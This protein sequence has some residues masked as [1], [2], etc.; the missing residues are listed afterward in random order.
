MV[1][2]TI[3]L[4]RHNCKSDRCPIELTFPFFTF[5]LCHFH[6][7]SRFFVICQFL[8]SFEYVLLVTETIRYLDYCS[9]AHCYGNN[10]VLGLLIMCASIRS[11]DLIIFTVFRTSLTNA[12]LY[13]QYRFQFV[14]FCIHMRTKQVINRHFLLE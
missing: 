11:Y 5:P 9:C 6:K 2:Q 8:T 14:S 3:C 7:S 12:F 10:T 13:D 4:Y 1:N